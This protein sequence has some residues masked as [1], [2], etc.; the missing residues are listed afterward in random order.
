MR[1]KVFSVAVLFASG[2]IFAQKNVEFADEMSK[3]DINYFQAKDAFD[4]YFEGKDR[5][6]KGKGFKAFNRWSYFYRSRIDETGRIPNPA[7]TYLEYQKQTAIQQN[8]LATSSNSI[9]QVPGNWNYVG[10]TNGV[11]V[12]GGGAGR[13][14]FVEFHPTNPNIIYVGAPA[15]GLWVTTNG[16][17]TWS[18]NTDKMASIG[19]SALGIDPANPNIMYLGTGDRDGGDTYGFGVLKTTDGGLTWN[20]T[21]LWFQ[22]NQT[23]TVS[24]IIV[25]P[26]NSNVIFAATNYGIFKSYDGGINWQLKKSGAFKEMKMKPGDHNVIYA[27]YGSVSRSLDNGE[28]WSSVTGFASGIGRI[29]LAVTPHDPTYVYALAGETNANGAGFEGLYR[30]TNSGQSFTKMS[31]SPNIMGWAVSGND[32]GGQAWYDIAIT[33]SPTNKNE[34]VTG[35]VNI[36]RSTNG[37]STWSI[38]AHWYGGGGNPY[39]HADVHYLAYYPGSSGTIFAGTDGGIFK[40]TNNGSTWTDLSQG[41]QIGQMYKLGVSQTNANLTLTGWQ[42]NGTSLHNGVAATRVLGGDGMECAIDPSNANIMYGEYYYGEIEKSTNGGSGFNT[43]VSSGGTGVDEDGDW[44]TPYIINPTSPNTILVGKKQ[45]YRSTNGGASFTQYGSISAGGNLI[46]MAYAP[47]NTNYVYVSKGNDFY[48]STNGST[49][50]NY[51]SNLPTGLP[52]GAISYICVDP[53]NPQRVWISING[54]SAGKKVYF[55]PDNGQTWNDQSLNLPNIPVN[56]IVYHPGSNDGLYVGTEIGVYY[57]DA[58]LSNWIFYS[59]GLPNVIVD[60]LEV[61]VSTGKLRAATYGRGLWETDLYAPPVSKPVVDFIADHDSICTNAQIN[62]YDQSTN[63]PSNWSW[64]F[65]GATPSTSNLQ[66]PSVTYSTPGLYQVKLIASNVAGTDS[67]EKINFVKVLQSP[68]ANAGADQ[69]I[70]LGDTAFLNATGG[71]LYTWSP[72]TNLNNAGIS[73]PYSKPNINRTYTVTVNGANGCVSTDVVSVFVQQ[74]PT[75]AYISVSGNTL[76]AIPANFAYNWYFNNVPM[77]ITTQTIVATNPGNYVVHFNDTLGCGFSDSAAYAVVGIKDYVNTSGPLVYPNP[78]TGVFSVNLNEFT[79]DL[80]QVQITDAI[81]KTMYLMTKDK[82]LNLN[83]LEIN[84]SF[85]P[86]VYFIRLKLKSSSKQVVSRF[87]VQNN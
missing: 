63:L 23:R 11:P 50:T 27:C 59:N 13:L 45:V 4:N 52:Q 28:T 2:L 8:K 77:G 15:G 76:T 58:T 22:Y 32:S 74:A 71:V 68:T 12:S 61:Q 79:N 24:S 17:S 47:S 85:S 73:N 56:T 38:D 44:V 9:N 66:F 65:P 43:I 78:N 80:E 53:T 81:G 51:S 16:G 84:A 39:V 40:T 64:S 48:V 1:K 41:L 72:T 82:L 35:G 3:P 7:V 54:F 30:S 25:D 83:K 6:E 70:C 19:V 37:G 20:P 26:T 10:P 36:W 29:A 67:I 87:V 42:D 34:I 62:F 31:S 18:T 75:A 46:A 69:Y 14:T 5:K 60:E 21:G 86:G 33:A 49:F 57:K 55:S